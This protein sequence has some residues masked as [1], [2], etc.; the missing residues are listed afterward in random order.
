VH[1]IFLNDPS[2]S[3]ITL[4]SRNPP[5]H[6]AKTTPKWPGYREGALKDEDWGERNPAD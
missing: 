3:Y 4:K 5:T 6:L 2:C 1:Q